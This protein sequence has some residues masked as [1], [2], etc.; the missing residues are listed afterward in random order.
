M[1]ERPAAAALAEVHQVYLLVGAKASAGIS[2]T[3]G[4]VKK[5]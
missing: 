4:S 2:F 5:H 1:V 3:A